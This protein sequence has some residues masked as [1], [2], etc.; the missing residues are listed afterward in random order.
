MI[1]EARIFEKVDKP[2]VGRENQLY[3]SV[4]GARIVAGCV[5][6][7]KDKR[8]VL[9]VSS[10]AHKKKWI[11]PKG[12]VE[13]DEIDDFSLTAQRETWEEAGCLGKIVGSLGIVEDMRPP[14]EW[15]LK[16]KDERKR[17][18]D[19][20]LHPPRSEFHF[21]ELEIES[22]PDIYPESE[23]RKRKF[24]PYKD[25]VEQLEIAKRP[26]L[27]EALNRSSIMKG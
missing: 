1:S 21:Y 5:C 24:F 8:Q 6:L 2:R 9:M 13:T 26:E 27:L 15:N 3:S 12:G 7:S 14:K 16:F 17:N 23:K 22:M 11:L 25:A 18:D 20:I 4:T 19:I 10:S